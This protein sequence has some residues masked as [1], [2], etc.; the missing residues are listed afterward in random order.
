MLD[1]QIVKFMT[2]KLETVEI[3]S[4]YKVSKQRR[5][6]NFI[7]LSAENVSSLNKDNSAWLINT[8]FQICHTI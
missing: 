5:W 2:D 4:Y 8:Q 7:D 6:E 1:G 3:I